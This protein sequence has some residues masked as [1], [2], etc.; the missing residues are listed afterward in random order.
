MKKSEKLSTYHTTEAE[1]AEAREVFKMIFERPESARR[2]LLDTLEC[3]VV[4]FSNASEITVSVSKFIAHS[5]DML[6]FL[7]NGAFAQIDEQGRQTSSQKKVA[8]RLCLALQDDPE[9]RKTALGAVHR[10]ILNSDAYAELC[11]EFTDAPALL[12]AVDRA[13]LMSLVG[14]A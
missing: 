14:N 6:N 1:R 13:Y 3:D 11:E 4:D 8:T 9:I 10:F 5:F 2:A 7:D 12:L